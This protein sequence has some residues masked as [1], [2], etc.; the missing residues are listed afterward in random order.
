MLAGS[1][2]DSD[3]IFHPWRYAVEHF[4]KSGIWQR[5]IHPS[6]HQYP[7][8][9]TSSIC[10]LVNTQPHTQS[11]HNI[12]LPMQSQQHVLPLKSLSVSTHSSFS[13][14]FFHSPVSLLGAQRCTWNLLT[15]KITA[16][17]TEHSRVWNWLSLVLHCLKPY[18]V[19]LSGRVSWKLS[20]NKL[21]LPPG[22]MHI[23]F[24]L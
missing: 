18:S 20:S 10:R 9:K 15:L 24:P 1:K 3:L 22:G 4:R 19:T 17:V 23:G 6:F 12:T 8:I 2:G 16:R 13:S 14:Q 11:C 21:N 5:E 7:N